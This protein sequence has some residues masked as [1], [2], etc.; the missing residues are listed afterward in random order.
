MTWTTLEGLADRSDLHGGVTGRLVRLLLDGSRLGSEDVATR[1]ARALSV[2]VPAQAKAAWVD[3]FL[4]DGG[5]LLVHD[6][7]LLSLLDGWLATLDAGTFVDVLP[8]LRRTFG[9]FDDGERRALGQRLRDGA[10]PPDHAAAG[11]T[12]DHAR[13]EPAVRTVALLLGV[14][15]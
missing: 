5:M 14:R 15:S 10:R 8:L 4:S 3:G 9:A 6:A 7:E 2:G 11:T 12:V 1:L 13:A